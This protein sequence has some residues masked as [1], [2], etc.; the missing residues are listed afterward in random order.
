[1]SYAI[2]WTY[3]VT[4]GREEAFRAAYGPDGDW[5]RLFARAAGFLGVELYGDG[6]RY[7]SIDRWATAEA[8]EAFQERFSAE[9]AAL[10]AK[11]AP[12]TCAQTRLGAFTR[13][14]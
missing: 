14:E 12:L 6:A 10:D 4:P 2:L 1:M 7:L 3:E 9:Y 5:A 8:F 13:A 11:L